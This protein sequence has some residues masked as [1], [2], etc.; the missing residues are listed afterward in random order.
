M[1][2]TPA[3]VLRGSEDMALHSDDVVRPL[4]LDEAGLLS[5]IVKTYLDKLNYDQNR[6]R[7]PLDTSRA[8]AAATM[9][10]AQAVE[11]SASGG[12]GAATALL[13]GNSVSPQNPFGLQPSQ[14]ESD[15]FNLDDFSG[16]PTDIQRADIVALLNVA[17]PGTLLADQRQMA[18][19]Q[20]LATATSGP[21]GATSPVQLAQAQQSALA[22]S[23]F[24][25]TA[26]DMGGGFGPYAMGQSRIPQGGN[27]GPGLPGF[28][29]MNGGQGGFQPN[30]SAVPAVP[31]G[32]PPT[33][34]SRTSPSRPAPL[35]ATRK[36]TP[37][38]TLP[39][40]S[41]S[42]PWFWSIS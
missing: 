19:Q 37:S 26:T 24:G 36:S 32:P 38:A 12:N 31:M 8:D 25:G 40:N 21:N 28:S 11:A 15:N 5:Y 42:T 10:A 30:G 20:A 14:L 13:G 18:F 41:V 2:F 9:Q 34:T 1:P 17:A 16:V 7:N 23:Q 3:A 39:A 29:G 33:A 27:Q 22:M 4:S 35:P 6:V